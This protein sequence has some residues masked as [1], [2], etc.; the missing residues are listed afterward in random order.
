MDDELDQLMRELKL[1]RIP[2]VLDKEIERA[3]K[4][5]VSYVTFLKRLLRQERDA[6]VVRAM[7]Y[8][9][10]RAKLPERWSLGMMRLLKRYPLPPPRL[11]LRSAANP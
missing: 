9:I 8:R 11:P 1:R 4:R 3:T 6:Q 2:T 10:K 7:E 5:G